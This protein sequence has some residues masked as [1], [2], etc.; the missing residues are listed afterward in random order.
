MAPD[1]IEPNR[2]E[3]LKDIIDELDDLNQEAMANNLW[4]R[5][6]WNSANQK[7]WHLNDSSQ[8][9]IREY[10]LPVENLLCLE[11]G[12]PLDDLQ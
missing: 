3:E 5:T 4:I 8:P 12:A 2:A 9:K 1:T 10:G 7:P 6:R 11:R